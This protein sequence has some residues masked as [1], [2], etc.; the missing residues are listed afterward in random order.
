VAPCADGSRIGVDCFCPEV[1]DFVGIGRDDFVGHR[2]VLFGSHGSLKQSKVI[3]Y[4]YHHAVQAGMSP[5]GPSISRHLIE[6]VLTE[7]DRTA[8]CTSSFHQRH[9]NPHGEIDDRRRS[10][11]TRKQ[12]CRWSTDH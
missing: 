8:W 6:S 11:I 12:W 9:S 5:G 10:Q 1:A 2:I 3:R 4:I 7:P